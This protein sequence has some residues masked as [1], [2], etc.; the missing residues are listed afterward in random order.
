MFD[1]NPYRFLGVHSNSGIKLIQKNLSKIKAYSKVGKQISLPYEL[2]FFHLNEID[3]SESSI[4][5]AENKILLDVN[6]V[7]YS[8]FWFTEAN[9]FDKIA[10]DNLNNGKFEKSET[11][12]R[13]LINGKSISKS[14][15]SAFN[16]LS[17]LLFL[18]SLSEKKNDRFENSVNSINLIQEALKLKS[19]L[20]F[21]KQLNE[22][23]NLV[24]GNENAIQI[25][26]LQE[27]F[28]ENIRLLFNENFSSKEIS[29][30]IKNSNT[31]LSQ[32]FNFSIINEPIESLRTLINEA[33]NRLNDDNS[34][35]GEIG[36][37]LIK[38][39]I[40]HLRLLKN[41]LGEEDIKYQSIADK[42][43]NQIMQCGILYFNKTGDDKDYVSSYKYAKTISFK[44]S[45]IQRANTTIKHCKELENAGKCSF[46]NSGKEATYSIKVQMHKFNYG[47]NYTYFKN[48][49]LEIKG[50]NSCYNQIS[51]KGQ[52]PYLYTI[53]IY[54]GVNFISYL[55]F[56]IPWII[57][58]ELGILFL[59]RVTFPIFKFVLKEFKKP[60][61]E[62]LSKHPMISKLKLEGYIFGMP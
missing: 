58:I 59:A 12:W 19:E 21:S 49:G 9:S 25:E 24:S 15:F 3:R 32:S 27:F 29:D 39:S 8:L 60:Y 47:G 41:I 55:I 23:S 13:K 6:K 57:C 38:D 54:G 50:C 18:R 26:N 43:A 10:L 56:E 44:D 16:N 37:Q 51:Q 61:Y 14:N 52:L 45:T 22:L 48:G 11:I 31:Q 28:N 17:T 30:I 34:K 36:K 20:I 40:Q 4:K 53:I 1:S 35:G 2:N 42:L 46:C 7:N 62:K 5:D 33:N